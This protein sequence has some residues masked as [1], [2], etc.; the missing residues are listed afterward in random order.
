MKW[1]VL[2]LIGISS[3]LASA[4][5]V[6]TLTD[7][8]SLAEI[9][10]PLAKQSVLLEEKTL[11]EIK[12][13]EKEK[14]PKLD[15]NAQA[16]Y[17]SD[18]IEFPFQIPNSTVEPPNKDQYRA[19]LDANQLIYNGGNIAAAKKLK[20]AELA[21]QQQ[22]ITVDLYTLK[23]RINQSYFSIL[24]FQEQEKLLTSK[25]EQLRSRL[26]EV[27]TGVKYGAIL[28]ASQQILEAEILKLEQQFSQVMIDRQK[29]LTHLSLLLSKNLDPNTS[30]EN[31][32]ILVSSKTPYNRPELKLFELQQNQLETSKEVLSKSKYPKLQAFAQA[33]Y[34]NPGLNMLDNSFQDFYLAG[35]KLNW[36]I[37]DWGRTKEKKQIL[38]ISKEIITTEKETFLLNN[39][40]Q[41]KEAESDIRKYTELLQKD[42]SI[43]VLRENILQATTSQLQ[44][45][46]I[47]SSQYITE[48]N[49]LYEA[50]IEKQLHQIQL[51]LAK[52]NYKVISADFN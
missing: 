7:C 31:P 29:A 46:T 23:S 5:E 21:T 33:G 25:M 17:Q 34:G 48:L 39:Q 45:G 18:V 43:I 37:F 12:V 15:L 6:L 1:I 38:D 26:K 52:A 49:N 22:K 35:L 41:Q 3:F 42:E 27:G 30:L 24:L 19:S 36:N 20:S 8:Y 47:T 10:Y 14:L 16:T 4:Q 50:K 51:T 11:S 9:N 44:N 40:M 2:L 13:L 32:E 28:P